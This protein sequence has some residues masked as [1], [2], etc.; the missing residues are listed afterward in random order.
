TLSPKRILGSI[1]MMSDGQYLIQYIVIAQISDKL[2]QSIKVSSFVQF[3]SSGDVTIAGQNGLYFTEFDNAFVVEIWE[4]E[5]SVV[6]DMVDEFTFMELEEIWHYEDR[7][8]VTQGGAIKSL[9]S[10]FRIKEHEITCALRSRTTDDYEPLWIPQLVFEEEQYAERESIECVNKMMDTTPMTRN[11]RSQAPPPDQ[12]EYRPSLRSD[13]APHPHR[14]EELIV[15]FMR[16]PM[17]MQRDVEEPDFRIDSRRGDRVSMRPNQK[18]IGRPATIY[19]GDYAIFKGIL[20]PV[21]TIAHRM[22]YN[23]EEILYRK[24]LSIKSDLRRY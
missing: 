18:L 14:E 15:S 16:A 3:S 9:L 17:T 2:F 4:L 1:R 19:C 22:S 21:L 24:L 20:P 5:E 7:R 8:R 13:H 6:L 11:L 12:E 23:L 10:R